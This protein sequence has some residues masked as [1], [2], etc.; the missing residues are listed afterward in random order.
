MNDAPDKETE[1]STEADAYFLRWRGK[2]TGPHSVDQILLDFRK[3]KVSRLHQVSLD[4]RMWKALSTHPR[5]FDLLR[6]APEPESTPEPTPPPPQPPPDTQGETPTSE[7]LP[8]IPSP[9]PPVTA[10]APAASP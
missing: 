2:V 7:P 5:F 8:S 1:T 3:G 9:P 4:R 10:P 6:D